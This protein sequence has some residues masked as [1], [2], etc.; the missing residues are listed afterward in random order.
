LQRHGINSKEENTMNARIKPLV[1]GIRGGLTA[2]HSPN[3]VRGALTTN[4]SPTTI[5]RSWTN[6]NTTVVRGWENHSATVVRGR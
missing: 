5:R 2:N 4:H 6:H 1:V 3:V